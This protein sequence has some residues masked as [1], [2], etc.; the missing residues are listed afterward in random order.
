MTFCTFFRDDSDSGRLDRKKKRFQFGLSS[1]DDEASKSD[2]KACKSHCKSRVPGDAKLLTDGEIDQC[3]DV[4][5][6][7]EHLR[8]C[9]MKLKRTEL[10]LQTV[11][12]DHAIEREAFRK[13]EHDVSSVNVAFREETY[14]KILEL[15]ESELSC[16]VCNEVFIQVISYSIQQSRIFVTKNKAYC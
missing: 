1:D 13:K 6:L 11:E 5:A 16:V 2:V 7:K 14:K 10:N 8:E 15:M 9:M 4:G 3:N 12:F